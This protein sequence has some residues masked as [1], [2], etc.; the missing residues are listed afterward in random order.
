M[1]E[2][3]LRR[4]RIVAAALS[5]FFNSPIAG[6]IILIVASIAA[7]I[8]ANSPLSEGYELLLKYRAGGL[9][10]EHWV[11]DG[12]MAIFFLLVGLEIKRELVIGELATWSQRALPGFAALGGMAVP[13]LIYVGFNIGNSETIAGWAIP[14]A[15]DIAFALGVLALIGSRVPASLK[16]F[17][18]ALAILDDMGAV[19]I[20]ALFYTSSI[21]ITMLMAA[22]AVVVLLFI[23][24]RA[25]V[26]RLLP[27]LIAGVVL[28]FCML[29]SG[30]HAT[31]AGIVLAFFIPL[32]VKTDDEEAPL[33]KLE[34]V[35][36]S[37]VTFLVLP[38]FG[39]VNA[40]VALSG[41]T[42]GDLTS[43]VPVGV[44]LGLFLGKQVGI[45]SLSL[46]AI[47]FGLA[48]RPYNSSWLQ[49]YGVSVLCGIGFTM[50]LFIGN[51]AF[52][53]TPLLVDEVKVG[54]LA[55]SIIAALAGV[56]ILRFASP[57]RRAV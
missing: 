34:H 14:A 21:S 49:L 20:I 23:M 29:Q 41:M 18:S 40:G 43:P 10:V 28:W 50:S 16:I 45:F 4:P 39:F 30:V 33:Y 12:L 56:L 35:L 2:N 47:K 31:I 26:T 25:G 6:G 19:I 46:L 42:L 48:R 5:G 36:G 9:S 1:S 22:A 51:L 44:A 8:V 52:S 3:T 11:N 13:A 32:R 24:N 17:L 55:G 27:Y 15:T 53:Q 37:W 54:V 57:P 7:I 38:L